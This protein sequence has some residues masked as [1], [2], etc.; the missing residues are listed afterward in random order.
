VRKAAL[1]A[2]LSLLLLAVAVVGGAVSLH[3][4]VDL[5]VQAQ[6][7][8]DQYL[9]YAF[10]GGRTAV[11][12]ADRADHP[13]CLTEQMAGPS[14]GNS[15]HFQ[16]DRGGLDVSEGGL[17][18]LPFPPTDVWCVWLKGEG[19]PAGQVVLAAL[20]VDLYTADWIVYQG[21]ADAS[22][23]EAWHLFSTLGCTL[24]PEPED[25]DALDRAQQNG[26]TG[27]ASI[28][29]FATFH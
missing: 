24:V 27:Y 8:L 11:V 28:P 18:P 16:T 17:S 5:P 21:P 9:A 25:F 4:D 22:S 19:P 12:A 14:F 20:H 3:G 10:P 26:Q 29:D 13:A 6:A 1:L 15:V 2:A 23:V 7:R